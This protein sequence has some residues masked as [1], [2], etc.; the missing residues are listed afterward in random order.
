MKFITIVSD[1]EIDLLGQI[2]Y[3]NADGW[4][5]TMKTPK[6]EGRLLLMHMEKPIAPSKRGGWFATCL[7][8]VTHNQPVYFSN[9][10]P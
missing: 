2:E 5:P 6:R 9:S 8:I 4:I 10:K 3:L 7:A 1:S